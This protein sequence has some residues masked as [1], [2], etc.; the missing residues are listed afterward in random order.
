MRWKSCD[1]MANKR[2]PT[3]ISTENRIAH[4]MPQP[5]CRISGK[6][7]RQQYNNIK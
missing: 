4:P 7:E 1:M 2:G 6:A 3:L 5:W